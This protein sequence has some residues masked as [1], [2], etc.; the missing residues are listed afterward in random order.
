MPE[1]EP[2]EET[3]AAEPWDLTFFEVVCRNDG[4]NL[5]YHRPLGT[6]PVCKELT[7]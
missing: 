3:P 1:N 5:A 4:C 2:T 7:R 6:C